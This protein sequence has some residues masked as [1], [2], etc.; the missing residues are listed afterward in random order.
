ME[1]ST[2]EKLN[3]VL[4]SAHIEDFDNFKSEN[5]DKLTSYDYAFSN[6]MHDLIDKSD[7]NM[8]QLAV[9]AGLVESTFRDTINETKA[10]DRDKI[11][12]ICVAMELTL[13]ETNRALKLSKL[14]ELYS[15]EKRDALIILCI[16][17]KVYNVDKVD[18]LLTENNF[19][20]LNSVRTQRHPK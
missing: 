20:K 9:R 10:K 14:S 12:R 16:N 19:N 3:K 2:T 1:E 11:I 6:Y 7:L 8:Q 4:K 5:K 18:E 15:K 13:E 17:N